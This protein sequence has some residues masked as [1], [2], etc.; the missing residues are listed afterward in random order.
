MTN[1]EVRCSQGDVSEQYWVELEE[2]WK[3]DK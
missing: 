1:K 2:V 3:N